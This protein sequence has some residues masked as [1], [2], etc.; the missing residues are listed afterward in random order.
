MPININTDNT[1]NMKYMFYE[2]ISLKKIK[3]SSHFNT[4]N[5]P[6]DN[7]CVECF[8]HLKHH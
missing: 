5:I 1:N 4:K 3:I 7:I 2:C 8:D 6:K